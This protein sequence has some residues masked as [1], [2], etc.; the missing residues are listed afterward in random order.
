MKFSHKGRTAL[1]AAALMLAW[2]RP[3]LTP[4]RRHGAGRR[5]RRSPCSTASAATAGA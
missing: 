3:R 1:A 4:K 2:L 5:R